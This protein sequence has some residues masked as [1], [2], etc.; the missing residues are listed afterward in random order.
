MEFVGAI[1]LVWLTAGIAVVMVLN[2]VKWLVRRNAASTSGDVGHL[3]RPLDGTEGRSL[4]GP[5]PRPARPIV[6][7]NSL[8]RPV[9]AT[10]EL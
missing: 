10:P 3:A 5:L 1:L 9:A 4:P 7:R 8:T 6:V 2:A